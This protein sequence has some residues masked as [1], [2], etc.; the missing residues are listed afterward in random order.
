MH[1]RRAQGHNFMWWH[2]CIEPTD[3][4]LRPM[5]LV[6]PQQQGKNRTSTVGV[7]SDCFVRYA[8]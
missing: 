4:G 3:L 7:A 1:H 6:S 5:R 2:L 8:W